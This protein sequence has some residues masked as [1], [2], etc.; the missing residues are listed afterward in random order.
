MN[1]YPVWLYKKL[2]FLT[3]KVVSLI[4]NAAYTNKKI[5]GFF[6]VLYSIHCEPGGVGKNHHGNGKNLS[7]YYILL[8][9]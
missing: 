9:Q 6:R 8:L 3:S 4:G 7:H 1:K 5:K 2:K